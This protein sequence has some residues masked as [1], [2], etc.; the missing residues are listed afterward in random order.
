VLLQSRQLRPLTRYFPEVTAALAE[1]LAPGTVLDG[2]I[3]G[4]QRRV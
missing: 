2:V 3:W 4:Q 1:Q